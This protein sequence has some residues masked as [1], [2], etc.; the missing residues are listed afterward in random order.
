[1]LTLFELWDRRDFRVKTFS[2]GMKR[3][4]EIAR[5]FLHSPKSSFSMNQPSVSTLR[6]ETF[7]GRT[8]GI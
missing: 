8:S 4:L 5:G 6:A 7:S 2:G 1:M 3:R